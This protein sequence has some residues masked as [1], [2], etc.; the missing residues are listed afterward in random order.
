MRSH[1]AKWGNSLSLRLPKAFVDRLHLKEGDAVDLDAEDGRLLV[2]PAKPSYD[3][4]QLLA[5]ITKD[6][7]PE[8]IDTSPVGQEIL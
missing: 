6:N 2:T 8:S 7:Q 3:L 5:G 4:K 1:I